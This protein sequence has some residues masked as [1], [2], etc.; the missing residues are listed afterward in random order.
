MRQIRLYTPQQLE[1]GSVIEL[2][3]IAAH[4]LGKVLRASAGDPV[5]LFNGEGLDWVCSVDRIEKKSLWI[6][7]LKAQDAIAEAPIETHLGLCLSKGDRFDWAIQKAT[8]LGISEITPLFSERVDIKIPADR[9]EK[10]LA[11]WRQIIIS[12]CEQCGRAR[13][14][15]IHPPKH[16]AAWVASAESALKWVLDHQTSTAWPEAAPNSIDLLIGPEGGLTEQEIALAATAGFQGLRLGPRV[17]RTET[18]PTVA[19]GIIGSRW[20]DVN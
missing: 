18:A 17:L 13:V 8:E 16:L 4:H 15:T 19:L 10:R 14:P 20:G 1:A 5:T 2:D 6:S 7:V 12:A 9:Q 11:H 3:T